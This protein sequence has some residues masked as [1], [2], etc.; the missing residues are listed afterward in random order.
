MDDITLLCMWFEKNL[1]LSEDEALSI[2]TSFL[3]SFT[4]ETKISIFEPNATYSNNDILRILN[5]WELDP[6]KGTL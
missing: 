3:N 6:T 1:S 5:E 4:I 2:T